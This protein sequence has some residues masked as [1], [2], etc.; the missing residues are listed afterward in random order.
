MIGECRS[1]GIG[2]L[3]LTGGEPLLY[4]GLDEVLEAAAATG[5]LKVTVCTNG[6][7]IS[8][9]RAARFREMGC[10]STSYRRPPRIP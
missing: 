5:S 2:T 6:M 9:Q 10:G 1:L 8:P 4:G 7:L 3:S